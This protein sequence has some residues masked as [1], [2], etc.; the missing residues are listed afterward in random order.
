MGKGVQY[1]MSRG[2]KYDGWGVR[3]TMDME[4]KI[5]WIKG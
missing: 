1:T 2:S 5:P 4:F 3:Y